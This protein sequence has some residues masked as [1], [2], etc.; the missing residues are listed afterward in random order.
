[1]AVIK[2]NV[3]DTFA[4]GQSRSAAGVDTIVQYSGAPCARVAGVSAPTVRLLKPLILVAFSFLLGAAGLPA[5]AADGT[6]TPAMIERLYRS[7]QPALAFQRVDKAIAAQPQDSA[8]RFLRAVML[9]DSRREA[10]ARTEY[11][12]LTQDFPELPEPFNNLAV[13][14]AAQGRLDNARDLLETAL[15]NDPSYRTAHANLGDVYARLALRS[16]TSA[17]SAPQVD[18]GLANKLRMVREL[19]AAPAARP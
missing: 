2:V 9:G 4:W 19:V 12:K 14:Q 7:G 17:A 1:M 6:D 8:L 11:E 5:D 3:I 10:E 18:E 15:R 16:Y 13:M